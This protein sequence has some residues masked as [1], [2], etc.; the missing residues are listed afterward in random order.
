[1]TV[2]VCCTDVVSNGTVDGRTEVVACCVEEL[3]DASVDVVG[4]TSVDDTSFDDDGIGEVVEVATGSVG[5]Y[6]VPVVVC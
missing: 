6:V 4:L 3:V 1:M 5:S 2:L